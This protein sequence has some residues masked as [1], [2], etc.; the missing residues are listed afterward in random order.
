MT[1][2]FRRFELD[3]LGVS[4]THISGVGSMK[5]GDIEFVYSGRKDGVHR[6]GVGLMMNN[7][8]AK[9]CSGWEGINN[10]ILVAH[11]M[12]KKFRLSVIVVYAP[13]EPTDGDS[14]DSDEFYLQLQEQVDR[15]LYV[16][17]Y[18]NIVFLLGD[19][20]AQAGRN[21]DRRYN[22]LGKF[23]VGKEKSNG[24][25]LCSYNN[26]VVYNNLVITNTVFGH[27]M[28]YKLT[29]YSRDGKTV[30]LIDYVIVN[31][32]LAGS[33]QDTRVYRGAVI[34]FKSKDHYLVVSK[35]NLCGF[36]KGR[37]CVDQVFTLRLIIEKS[38]RCQTPLVLSFIGY[39][40]PISIL[41]IEKG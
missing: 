39:D 10:R 25:R 35:V 3:L 30:N 23:G 26:F 13:V 18:R 7:E 34:D 22:S 4:E 41:L 11:F 36:R 27:K 16:I 40:K 21:R 12:T 15:V 28:T 8:A 17:W 2:E 29:W 9:S 5:L 1:D 6:Q 19:F 14:S 37:G 38:L 32:R 20:D 33:I 31:R 24:H